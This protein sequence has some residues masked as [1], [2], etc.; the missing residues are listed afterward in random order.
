MPNTVDSNNKASVKRLQLPSDTG[1]LEVSSTT[2]TPIN[3]IIQ[4][5]D[6]AVNNQYMQNDEQQIG[7]NL[8]V[9]FITYNY[10]CS[11]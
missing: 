11:T 3:N 8:L 6:N 5:T 10:D 4:S 7:T 1:S 9:F 2:N